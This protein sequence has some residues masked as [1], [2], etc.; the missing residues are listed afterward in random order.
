MPPQDLEAEMSLLG[1]MLLDKDAIGLIVQLI[2]RDQAHRFYRPDHRLLFE[3]L[4]D[5][6]EENKPI[7]IVIL[8]EELRR[9]GQMEAIGGRD[10]LIDLANSVPSSAN[11]EHYAHIVRDKSYLRDLIQCSADI[12]QTAYDHREPAAQLLDDAEKRLF[13]VTEQRIS[14]QVVSI[15]ACL[16]LVIANMES[17]SGA[18]NGVPSGFLELDA[19]LG[20]F[21]LGD[22]IIIAA[23][24]SMGKT[25]LGLSMLENIGIVEQKPA[26]FFSLEMSKPQIAQRILCSHA[27]VDMH[28]LRHGRLSAQEITKLKTTAGG[29]RNYAIFVDDTPGMS[30]MELR[31]K[32]RRLK[33]QHN[34]EII[35]IDYLQLMSDR[36]AARESRQQE[37]ASISRG[38]KALARELNIPVVAMA[39]LNRQVE[40]RSS[41]R[42]RMSDLR[43]SGAIEQDADVVMLLHREEYYWDKKKQ[44]EKSAEFEKIH[45]K[46]DL[47]IDKQRNGPTGTVELVFIPKLTR[48]QTAFAGHDH[49]DTGYPAADY[50]QANEDF[51]IPPMDTEPDEEAPF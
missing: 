20:G 30:V 44:T 37:V 27:E 19:M 28:K 18:C 9:R 5:L 38:L 12:L 51:G 41:N 2:P 11:S 40:D 23:R 16:D 31:A 10:Y 7:D 34:I 42:P 1:S 8:E 17:D 33:M 46:A 6:Y 21:Q 39:Q 45:G 4:L 25:S 43:E 22:L 48:F 13:A 35:F 50:G 14:Q 32:S 3:T 15:H 49:G 26:A 29:L 36:S 47:I 24:P